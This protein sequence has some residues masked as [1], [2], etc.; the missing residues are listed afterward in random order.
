[1]IVKNESEK[2]G[3]DRRI[4][5]ERNQLWRRDELMNTFKKK[6]FKRYFCKPKLF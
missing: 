4:P 3:C 6:E 5:M 2:Y 1:M